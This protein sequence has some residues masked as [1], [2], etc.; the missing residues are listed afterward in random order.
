MTSKEICRRYEKAEDKMEAVKKMAD[1][2]GCGCYD[3]I[4]LLVQN[5]VNIIAIRS[6]YTMIARNR[7][8]YEMHV[9]GVRNTEI[10]KL[11]H[12]TASAISNVITAEKA[13][14]ATDQSFAES[15]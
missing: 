2:S 14:C 15:L 10:G 7:A 11:F 5:K 12:L 6:E 13:L 1:E 9:A 3:I 8:I 4:Y